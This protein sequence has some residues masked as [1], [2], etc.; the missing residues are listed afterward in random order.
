MSW[1]AGTTSQFWYNLGYIYPLG[2]GAN[3]GNNNENIP[4]F[5]F[6]IPG[7]QR[8]YS[9]NSFIWCSELAGVCLLNTLA[10]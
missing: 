2:K 9:A 6:T 7:L 5:S 4:E 1:C 8:G 10:F 3:L